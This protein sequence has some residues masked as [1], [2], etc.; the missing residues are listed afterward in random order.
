MDEMLNMTTEDQIVDPVY[1]VSF[2]GEEPIVYSNANLY[3]GGLEIVFDT[4]DFS[5]VEALVP[6]GIINAQ[7][8]NQDIQEVTGVYKDLTCASIV[9]DKVASCVIVRLP[10]ISDEAKRYDEIDVKVAQAQAD[11]D[12]LAME[13]GIEL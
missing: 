1:A 6:E 9:L 2:N 11:I 13:S 12:Y 3:Q 8:I 10:K 4:E 7:L 5:A